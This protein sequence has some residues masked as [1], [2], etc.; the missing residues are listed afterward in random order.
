MVGQESQQIGWPLVADIQIEFRQSHRPTCL[1]GVVGDDF[2][3][4]C[5]GHHIVNPRSGQGRIMSLRE[6]LSRSFD[7]ALPAALSFELVFKFTRH[8]EGQVNS[9]PWSELVGILPISNSFF[10]SN[11]GK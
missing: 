3:W 11:F 2:V 1:K 7:K 6:A 4:Q 10:E 8:K 5:A 9:Q